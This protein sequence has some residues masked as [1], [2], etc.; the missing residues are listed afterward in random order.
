[1]E[2][3]IIAAMILSAILSWGCITFWKKYSTNIVEHGFIA[4]Y[5]WLIF[6]VIFEITGLINLSFVLGM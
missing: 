5:S 2:S 6:M 4:I 1:M 3:N